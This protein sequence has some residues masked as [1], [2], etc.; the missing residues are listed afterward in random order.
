MVIGHDQREGGQ[1]YERDQD[2]EDLLGGV[3]RRREVVRGEHRERRG[4]AQALV[5][6]LV[7]VH[8]RAEQPPLQPVARS[9]S[10]GSGTSMSLGI[11]SGASS[12]VVARAMRRS[13]RRRPQGSVKARSRLGQEGA[14]IASMASMGRLGSHAAAGA[15]VGLGLA[16]A[17]SLV[18]APL[19][20]HIS[21]ATPALALTVAVGAS[22]LIGGARAAVVVAI[23]SALLLDLVFLPPY[24]RVERADPRGHGRAGQLPPRRRHGRRPRHAGTRPTARGRAA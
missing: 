21:P 17:M 11:G 15:L 5:V 22:A 3:G 24:G 10:G 19:R 14:K 1:P 18:L 16:V 13:N 4:L 23:G 7:G 8:R 2:V 9:G 20:D 6:H 12:G